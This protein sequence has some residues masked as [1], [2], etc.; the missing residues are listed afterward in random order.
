[1]RLS[2]PTMN[3]ALETT[4][5]AGKHSFALQLRNQRHREE[6]EDLLSSQNWKQEGKI[7]GL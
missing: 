2:I 5:M 4:V 3:E 6:K 1:M 7:A